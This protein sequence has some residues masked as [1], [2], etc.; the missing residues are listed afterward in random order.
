M[1]STCHPATEIREADAMPGRQSS[2]S[3]TMRSMSPPL[4]GLKSLDEVKN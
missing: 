3:P 4:L 1:F 2:G